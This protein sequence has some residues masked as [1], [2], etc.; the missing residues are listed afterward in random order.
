[1]QAYRQN[2]LAGRQA[3]VAPAEEQ[4]ARVFTFLESISFAKIRD[5]FESGAT[6]RRIAAGEDTLSVALEITS[7]SVP[8][9]A[10]LPKDLDFLTPILKTLALT[11]AGRPA[12]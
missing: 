10:I 11:G 5:E 12:S 8:S 4:V 3:P 1:M 7:R 6:A 2:C 9:V